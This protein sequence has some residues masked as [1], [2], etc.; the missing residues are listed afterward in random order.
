MSEKEVKAVVDFLK[1]N[2]DPNGSYDEKVAHDIEL[3]AAASAKGSSKSMAES[4]DGEDEYDEMLPQAIEVVVDAGEASTSLLQRKLRL[5]YARAGR[6]IDEMES[7]G[8]VGA[9]A[10]SKAREV[11]ITRQQWLEMSMRGDE[12]EN[13]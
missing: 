3:K 10:G 8:I 4:V 6:L 2:A 5:G 9:H 13:E 7:R 12:S 1:S 11:L